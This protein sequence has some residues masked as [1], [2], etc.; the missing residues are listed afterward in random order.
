MCLDLN[1]GTLDL[2]HFTTSVIANKLTKRAICQKPTAEWHRLSTSTANWA[3]QNGYRHC[4]NFQYFY[5]LEWFWMDFLSKS[6]R[7]AIGVMECN[8]VRP[9]SLPIDSYGVWILTIHTHGNSLSCNQLRFGNLYDMAV[10]ELGWWKNRLHF[11]GFNV[12]NILTL[13]M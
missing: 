9:M 7:T 3:D 5:V 10:G 6:L 8:T 4:R 1:S 2:R 12:L 11:C 13:I